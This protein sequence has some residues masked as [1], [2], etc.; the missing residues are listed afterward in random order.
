MVVSHTGKLELSRALLT[1][2][3]LIFQG[4]M[5]EDLDALHSVSAFDFLPGCTDCVALLCAASR[6][7]PIL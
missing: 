7:R 5:T 3:F 2:I 6:N 4:Q 1:Y